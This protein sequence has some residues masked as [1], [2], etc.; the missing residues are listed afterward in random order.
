MSWY[1][2]LPWSALVLCAI[3]LT[4]LFSAG[5]EEEVRAEPET[6]WV[7]VMEDSP[8]AILLK[9]ADRWSDPIMQI[10]FNEKVTWLFDVK[11]SIFAKVKVRG[12]I[13]YVKKNCLAEARCRTQTPKPWWPSA[14]KLRILQPR[15]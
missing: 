14:V 6:R 12:K 11:D 1:R 3:A 9:K 7:A 2:K 13:G 10:K 15:G 8:D 4:L 5:N